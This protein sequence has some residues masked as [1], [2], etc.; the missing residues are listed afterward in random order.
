MDKKVTKKATKKETK[1]KTPATPKKS[2]SGET[3]TK[4]K[5]VKRKK[6]EDIPD[7]EPAGVINKADDAPKDLRGTKRRGRPTNAERSKT[8]SIDEDLALVCADWLQD[9]K[10]ARKKIPLA[11]KIKALPN[12]L[13]H[14]VREDD[15]DDESE[16]TLV[17][18]ADRYLGAQKTFNEAEA[19]SRDEVQS[20][21]T[22]QKDAS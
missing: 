2:E 19:M 21:K 22:K 18:L 4:K 9:I 1:K 20:N 10:T 17:L 5:T 7:E 3:A 14:L 13:K 16:L 8:S 12:M 15:V 11:V 6:V